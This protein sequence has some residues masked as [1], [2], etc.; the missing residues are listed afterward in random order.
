[1]PV[2]STLR[3]QDYQ[4]QVSLAGGTWRWVTRVDVSKS[5]ISTQIRDIVSPYGIRD[6]IPIP[7]EVVQA[8]A[9]SIVQIQ[10]SYPPSILL[11]ATSLTFV[12]DEGRGVSSAQPVQ[13]TNNGILGSL[14]SATVTSSA[15]YVFPLPANI[16]GLTVNQSGTF[17]VS[18]D[19]TNLL[20]IGSPYS[21]LLTVQSAEAPNSPQSIPVTIMVRPKAT[22]D[23]SSTSMTFTVAAP[24]TGDFPAI[25]SQQLTILNTGSAQS[26]LDYQ[27]KKLVGVSWLVSYAPIFGSINGG[28]SQ[29]V[30]VVVSPPAGMGVGSYTETLR[31]TG[32][33]TNM[34]K[35]VT[36][37]LNIT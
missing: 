2:Q 27:I 8:M 36:V 35:D 7:G 10:D 16:S 37:T 31:I 26:S 33:S 34:T 20:S 24:L 1:M 28:N 29:A 22:I 23:V 32:Y 3:Y 6:S 14:L 25:P 5:T 21:T 12:V 13:I 11:G 15:P 30:T 17:D 18:V 4:F 19:S 9:D